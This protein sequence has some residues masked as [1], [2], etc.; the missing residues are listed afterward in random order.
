M[1]LFELTTKVV[2]PPSILG[3]GVSCY[4]IGHDM[5][6]WVDILG[7]KIYQMNENT[8]DTTGKIL[9]LNKFLEGYDYPSL[10]IPIQSHPNLF[11]TAFKNTIVKWN[12]DTNCIEDTYATLDQPN[13]RFNDGKCDPRGR[14]WIGTTHLLDEPNQ[15]MLYCLESSKFLLR[16]VLK[17]ISISNG[18]AWSLNGEFMYYIDTPKQAIYVYQYDINTGNIYDHTSYNYQL[19]DNINNIKDI[20]DIQDIQDINPFI[21]FDLTH[22]MGVPDGM[23]IDSEGMLWVAMWDGSQILRIDPKLMQVI[24]RIT[25]KVSRPTYVAISYYHPGRLYVTSARVDGETE[26]GQLLIIETGGEFTGRSFLF[27]D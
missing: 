27:S 2:H 23:N 13:L 14:L 17:N 26:S 20:Q 8:S 16:P 12:I 10:I 3:E 11:L 6:M 4:N 18:I 21:I 15:A 9:Q 24:D 7:N 5:V 1:H 25:L 19:N 22:E